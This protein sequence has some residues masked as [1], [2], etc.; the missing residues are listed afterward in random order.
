MTSA[1]L[2]NISN[3]SLKQNGYVR[4][5]GLLLMSSLVLSSC[6]LVQTT[7]TSSEGGS[8]SSNS[9]P[10]SDFEV[11]RGDNPTNPNDQVP[12]Q[13]PNPTAIDPNAIIQENFILQS[14]APY[15]GSILLDIETVTLNRNLMKVGFDSQCAD[16]QWQ[17]WSQYTQ[18]ALMPSDTNK[19]VNVSVQY[20]DWDL[21]ISP[22]YNKQIVQ[23][24]SGPEILFQLYPSAEIEEGSGA[25]I[26]FFISDNLTSVRTA[27]C[28][29]NGVTKNCF[30]GSNEVNIPSLSLGEY[31]F[32][33]QAAD[34]IGNTASKTI[35]WKVV[36]TTKKMTQNILVDNYKK[37]DVL[38]VIDNSGS[39][40]YEQKSM[41]SRTANFISVLKGLDWQI[42]ITTTDPRDIT[43]GDG[44]LIPL[45]GLK[46]RYIIDSTWSDTSAQ[47][48]LGT[49]LQRSETGSGSEQGIRAVYRSIERYIAN[50]AN[51]RD[52]IRDQSQLAVVLISDEDESANSTKNNPQDLLKFIDTTFKG[53]KRFN[54][55]SIITRPGDKACLSTYG[56]T[57]G[58]RY[59]IMSQL[60][61]GI[62][63]DVCASDYAAQAKGIAQEIRNL[64]KTLT[65][66]CAPL[67]NQPITVTKNGVVISNPFTV[68]GVNIKF[69]TELEPGEYSVK[70]SCLNQ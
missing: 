13:L 9:T 43:L 64:L 5:A 26:K 20:Q 3:L 33:V 42:G 23:D 66:A 31:S 18:I 49:T 69:D 37:I 4:L 6:D 11:T 47:S 58:E 15:T 62:I 25:G 39:M 27:S 67:S 24:S 8:N 63:G 14:G 65:L 68:E 56:A 51:Q 38:F 50:E 59:Q 45:S 40:A 48:T 44:R 61:G 21:N 53:Q 54:F 22:C 12:V 36:S 52:L 41:A 1:T 46:N 60:T 57:Y 55:H 34:I 10:S 19:T 2:K 70:Y 7:S 17:P 28:T 35:N 16:G 30:A 32:T 29:L